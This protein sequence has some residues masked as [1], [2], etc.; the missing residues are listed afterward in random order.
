MIPATA[1][2]AT[3]FCARNGIDRTAAL[4]LRLVIEELFTN[5]IR[6][7]IA[8]SAMRPFALRRRRTTA[9]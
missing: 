6:H 5:T 9:S 7:G 2:F 8:A 1:A 4:R 3:G